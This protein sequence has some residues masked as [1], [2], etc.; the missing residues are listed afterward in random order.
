MRKR[1]VGKKRAEAVGGGGG[2]GAAHQERKTSI[3]LVQK[4]AGNA[5]KVRG[6]V[7]TLEKVECRREKPSAEGEKKKQEEQKRSLASEV[8]NDSRVGFTYS[9]VRAAGYRREA[10]HGQE[11]KDAEGS[12][13]H[14]SY[15]TP[16]YK[17]R[18][19]EGS[20]AFKGGE[21]LELCKGGTGKKRRRRKIPPTYVG[22]RGG[23]EKCIKKTR[24]GRPY[25]RRDKLAGKTRFR[26][27]F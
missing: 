9:Q 21:E 25:W 6:E 27:P 14:F 8:K 12:K 3:A 23:R 15:D 2:G 10:K 17:G 26:A 20:K 7:F 1:N 11:G 22:L 4:G 19:P 5:P 16:R 18:S 13:R 24:K